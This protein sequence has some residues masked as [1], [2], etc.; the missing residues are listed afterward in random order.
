MKTFS[1]LFRR[2]FLFAAVPAALAFAGC[3]D[4]DNPATPAQGRVLISHAAASA[5]VQVK[6]LVDNAEVGQLNYG[7]SSSYLNVNAGSPTLKINVASSN[8]EAASKAVTIA[9]NQNYSAFA[10]SPTGQTVDLLAV[11]DDL[12]APSAGKAKIRLVHL[13]QG[14]SSPLKLSTT[15]AAVADIPNTETQ[16]ANASPFVEILP[17]SYNIAVTNGQQSTTVTNVGDG[18]GAGT[19]ANKTYE[20]GKIYTVLVR[21]VKNPLLAPALQPKAVIIQNN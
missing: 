17:G 4:D 1:T 2:S 20:A 14:E 12:T 16:F 15:V 8:T 3:G 9:A 5:N 13:G 21:G 10:Y 7:Q 6:A 19:V 18:S 11:T